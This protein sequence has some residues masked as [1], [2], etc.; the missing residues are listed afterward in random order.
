VS[1][2]KVSAG[3]KKGSLES[4][5]LFA[6]LGPDE[7][8][9]IEAACAWRHFEEGEDIVAYLDESDDVYFVVSGRARVVIYAASGKAVG[10]RDLLPGDMFGEYA[11]I[12]QA[13]RSASIEAQTACQVAVMPSEAF[14]AL[15]HDQP[16]VCLAL[17]R[18]LTKQ[19]RS[20]TH[21]VYEFSTL[22]VNNRIQAELLRLAQEAR[23]SEEIETTTAVI[24]PA[25]THMEI[26][27]RISSHRE[28]VS[29]E[30]S[31]LTREGLI[32]RRGRSLIIK[33]VPRL[34]RMVRTA[35]GE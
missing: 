7:L 30:L 21:R 8:G 31:R 2:I 33:D 29:R 3:R 12:D 1:V 32:E 5:P 11:A 22:A 15:F 23:S 25:P 27:G 18:H 24:S 19:L 13:P 34:R 16:A 26:A 14:R 9:S 28:A 35:T 10:F 4:V 6:D 17:I 20:L